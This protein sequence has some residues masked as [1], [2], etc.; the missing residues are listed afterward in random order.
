MLSIYTYQI[1]FTV[2]YP[3]G[4]TLTESRKIQA[5]T[6]DEIN[7]AFVEILKNEYPD[8]GVDDLKIY[9]INPEVDQK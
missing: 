4:R 5:G 2:H 6:S 3:D 9:Q 7:A 1:Q 8:L